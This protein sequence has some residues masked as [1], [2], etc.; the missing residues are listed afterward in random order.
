MQLIV[1]AGQA[2]VG[3]TTLA[4][5]IAKS[6][7]EFGM[8]PKLLSFAG[9]LKR[10]AA[11]K[12][13]DKDK[14]PLKYREFCQEYGAMRREE[15]PDHWIKEFEK[16]LIIIQKKERRDIKN[17]ERYWERCVIV[18][19][20]RYL[21]EVG[22]A[23]K[24]KASLIFM[25]YGDRPMPDEDESWRLHHSEE[26]ARLIDSGEKDYKNI[27]THVVI[28]DQSIAEL[29]EKVQDMI[30]LWCGIEP[31]CASDCGCAACRAKKGE[32]IPEVEQAIEMLMDLL[33]LG[34]LNEEDDEDEE[35]DYDE[36]TE[37][38]NT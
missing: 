8:R 17:K 23:M 33:F 12:G 2:R 30:P 11:E 5:I 38:D 16:E 13:Y 9:P 15:D 27:F 14:E 4:N 28:N 31:P 20:C 1:L 29:E 7:F 32:K 6:A 25:S 26:M 18:D 19:D 37:Q 10:L 21:N 35:E 22:L 36:E 3:K 24:F 34:N